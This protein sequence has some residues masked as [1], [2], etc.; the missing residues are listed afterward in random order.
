MTEI[1]GV[2]AIMEAMEAVIVQ[3]EIIKDPG[4]RV[5]MEIHHQL[6]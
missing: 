1:I 6:N 5:A 4:T 2:M 3:T